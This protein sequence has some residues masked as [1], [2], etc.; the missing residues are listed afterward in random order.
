MLL[1][2]IYQSSRSEKSIKP[3][4]HLSMFCCT[5]SI[6]HYVRFQL[7]TEPRTRRE[8]STRRLLCCKKKRQIVLLSSVWLLSNV[9]EWQIRR[10]SKY[11]KN[12]LNICL[13]GKENS[14]KK[15]KRAFREIRQNTKKVTLRRKGT[16]VESTKQTQKWQ[17]IKDFKTTGCDRWPAY[18]ATSCSR[19]AAPF[20]S[21]QLFR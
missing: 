5:K 13:F 21:C 15:Y 8:T 11:F 12:A 4:N 3:S 17:K 9:L 14:L 10:N 18:F 16:F 1:H 7:A 20:L 2:C 6:K 19:R